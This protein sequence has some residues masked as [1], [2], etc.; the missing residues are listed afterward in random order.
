MCG[1]RD[2]WAQPNAPADCL[3]QPLS[4]HVRRRMKHGPAWVLFEESFHQGSKKLLSLLSPRRPVND[5]AA[6]VEQLYID[7]TASLGERMQYK[8]SRKS[9]AYKPIIDGHVMHCGHE[10]FLVCIYAQQ[11]SIQNNVLYFIYRIIT[12]RGNDL[13][14]FATE[15]RQQSIEVDA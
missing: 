4:Y 12:K 7:R 1:W 13:K 3:R 2:H 5:V 9:A 6:F 8:K 14:D 11:T 10:P 15:E